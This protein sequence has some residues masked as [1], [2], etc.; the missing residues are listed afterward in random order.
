MRGRGGGCLSVYWCQHCQLCQSLQSNIR[1]SGD[2]SVDSRS[3]PCNKIQTRFSKP[4]FEFCKA[5]TT[6]LCVFIFEG[7]NYF[8]IKKTW[9]RYSLLGLLVC[10]DCDT[11]VFCHRSSSSVH[12]RYFFWFGSLLDDFWFSHIIEKDWTPW[13]IYQKVSLKLDVSTARLSAK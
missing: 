3:W 5:S 11:R 8:H 2:P 10:R 1:E 9:Q 4:S 13:L 7:E 12:N 6:S